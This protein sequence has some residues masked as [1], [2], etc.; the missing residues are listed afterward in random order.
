MS[1]RR[2]RKFDA[3]NLRKIFYGEIGPHVVLKG[4]VYEV[5]Y[6]LQLTSWGNLNY[7]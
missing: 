3:L 7:I 1:L 6:T 5:C 2:N 4:L